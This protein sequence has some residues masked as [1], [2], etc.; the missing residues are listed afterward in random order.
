MGNGA[1][2]TRQTGLPIVKPL[3]SISIARGVNSPLHTERV[4]RRSLNPPLRFCHVAWQ[5]TR[6]VDSLAQATHATKEVEKLTGVR[7]YPSPLGHLPVASCL[8]LFHITRGGGFG[9]LSLLEM[10]TDSGYNIASN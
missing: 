5:Q 9:R 4:P 7:T 8:E 6:T 10:T 1:S 3:K 2:A